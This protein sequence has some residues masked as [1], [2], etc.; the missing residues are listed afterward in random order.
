MS[1]NTRCSNGRLYMKQTPIH[2][3]SMSKISVEYE[4][5]SFVIDSTIYP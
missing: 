1:E 3:Q 2:G 4:I 5:S